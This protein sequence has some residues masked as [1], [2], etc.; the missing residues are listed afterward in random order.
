MTNKSRPILKYH[1]GK[2]RLAP[3]IISNFPNHFTYV[4]PFCGAASV[5]M[6]KTKSKI[7]VINDLNDRLVNVFKVLRDKESSQQLEM[8]LFRTPCSFSEY[9]EAREI[10]RDPIEDARRM[11]ILGHQGHGGTGVSGGKKSGWRRR[12]G[13][14]NG[15]N[16]WENIHS[17][18]QSWCDRL[19]GVYIENDN[20]LDVI[21]RWDSKKTLFYVDPPYVFSTR[22]KNCQNQGYSYEMAD[23]DH[24]NLHQ[25]LCSIDGMAIISGY[26]CDLYD[27]LYS[28]WRRIEKEAM[29][30]KA[31][32]TIECIWIHPNCDNHYK[33]KEPLLG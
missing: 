26:E 8:S 17:M 14:G 1:G 24:I 20:A 12:S 5:L 2:W 31:K 7:E 25:A 10:H 27:R 18:V 23:K 33:Y 19:R 11:I 32:K 29:A 6:R 3:W 9:L 15:S 21:K 16:D 22:S 4:E 30:D 28:D 13:S